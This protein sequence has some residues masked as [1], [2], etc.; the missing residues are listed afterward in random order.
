MKR[1]LMAQKEPQELRRRM[2]ED[3]RYMR[4]LPG[5]VS[6]HINYNLFEHYSVPISEIKTLFSAASLA[7]VIERREMEIENPQTPEQAESVEGGPLLRGQTVRN[8]AP[9]AGDSYEIHRKWRESQ[10]HHS[11]EGKRRA[12][13]QPHRAQLGEAKTRQPG[14]RATRVTGAT[15]QQKELLRASREATTRAQEPGTTQS[16]GNKNFPH[17][18]GGPKPT[19]KEK[20]LGDAGE[21]QTFSGDHI[22]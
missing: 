22:P 16:S 21:I 11:E 3:I 15:A 6:R 19:D 18:V 1:R 8:M 5:C 10:S 9:E 14:G 12:L 4:Q 2:A 13:T 17:A 7:G 20:A